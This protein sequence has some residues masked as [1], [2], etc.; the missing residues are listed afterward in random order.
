MVNC[1]SNHFCDDKN[2]SGC[3]FLFFVCVDLKLEMYEMGAPRGCVV[4]LYLWCKVDFGVMGCNGGGVR[5]VFGGKTV[6]TC[7]N[8]HF[9]ILDLVRHLTWDFQW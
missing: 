3:P 4:I 5:H 9:K 1:L 8:A 2:R 7:K 6:V